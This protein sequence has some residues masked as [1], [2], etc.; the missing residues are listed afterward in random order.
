MGLLKKGST[1]YACIFHGDVIQY[2]RF[3]DILAGI[4]R[5]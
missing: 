5:R 4:V 3:T 1:K 2:Q